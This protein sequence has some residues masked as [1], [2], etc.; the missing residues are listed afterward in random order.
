MHCLSAEQ[1]RLFF[2]LL[3]TTVWFGCLHCRKR[4]CCVNLVFKG[5]VS[6]GESS[7]LD[8]SFHSLFL[9]SVNGSICVWLRHKIW[10]RTNPQKGNENFWQCNSRGEGGE[11]SACVLWGK[12]G[13]VTNIWAMKL[14]K[15][16]RIEFNVFMRTMS[17]FSCDFEFH[18]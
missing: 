9:W 11:E 4:F 12:G 2:F 17:E 10:V 15:W 3:N 1:S 16:L 7:D 18:L 8:G 13:W 5:S 14:P 6:L